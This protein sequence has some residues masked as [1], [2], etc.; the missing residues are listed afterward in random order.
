MYG[1]WN[2][3]EIPSLHITIFR[4]ANWAREILKR[5]RPEIVLEHAKR[6]R[7]SRIM[8]NVL[9]VQDWSKSTISRLIL[10]FQNIPLSSVDN[11]TPGFICVGVLTYRMNCIREKYNVSHIVFVERK[12]SYSGEVLS[13]VQG[14]VDYPMRSRTKIAMLALLFSITWQWFKKIDVTTALSR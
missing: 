3:R 9:M 1:I 7:K 10:S 13:G 8:H 12:A 6:E 11:L 2:S 4:N 5:G 14:K